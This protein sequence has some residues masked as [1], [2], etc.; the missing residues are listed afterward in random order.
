LKF[1][2]QRGRQTDELPLL[3]WSLYD[4][5]FKIQVA[6]DGILDNFPNRAVAF[7]LRRMVFPRGLTLIQPSDEMGHQVADLLIKPSAA[8]SRL[9]AGM[10]LPKS[11]TDLMGKLEAAMHAVIAAEPIDAKVRA[12]K[13]AGRL[14]GHGADAQYEEAMK[15][16]VITETEL[17]L[18]K[19]ARAL[20]HDIIMV[21]DFDTHFGK[22]TASKPLDWAHAEAAE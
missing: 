17:A 3:R 5:A 7:F 15:L 20:Q 19:R 12:A 21:D 2:D 8:R 22:Q 9:I 10:Y 6:M 13:K 16:S 4:S 18:W 1:Y 11:D 14:S